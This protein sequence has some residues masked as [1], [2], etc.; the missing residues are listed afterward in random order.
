VRHP[1]VLSSDVKSQI[2]LVQP[3]KS[4]WLASADGTSRKEL[5][6]AG[7]K[8]RYVCEAERVFT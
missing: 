1:F 4:E 6:G 3:G 8:L 2:V 7:C 5:A